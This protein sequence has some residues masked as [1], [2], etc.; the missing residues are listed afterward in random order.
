MYLQTFIYYD[1]IKI[2][3]PLGSHKLG[4]DVHVSMHFVSWIKLRN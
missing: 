2:C 1:E 4:W 3:N